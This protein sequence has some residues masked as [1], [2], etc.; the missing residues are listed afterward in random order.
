VDGRIVPRFGWRT[1]RA[2]PIVD[3][4][5]TTYNGDPT[6]LVNR[7]VFEWIHPL[8]DIIG[9]LLAAGMRLEW[10]HEF[11]ALPWPLFP[12]MTEGEDGLFRLPPDVPQLP[13]AFSLR[14]VK[15]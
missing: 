1:P 13:L 10:L 12:M 2:A 8:S 6:E 15:S 14:A 3:E 5:P 9:G 7:R 4:T 11:E